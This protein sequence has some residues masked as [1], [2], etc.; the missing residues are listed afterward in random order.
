MKRVRE[1]PSAGRAE[2]GLHRTPQVSLSTLRDATQLGTSGLG[3]THP[4][5]AWGTPSAAQL[6]ANASLSF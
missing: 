2:L 1:R 3:G 4:V 6:F 5:Y